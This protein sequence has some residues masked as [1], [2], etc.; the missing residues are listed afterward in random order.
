MGKEETFEDSPM[1]LEEPLLQRQVYATSPWRFYVLAVLSTFSCLQCANWFVFSSV[2]PSVAVAGFWSDFGRFC[3][4][5]DQNSSLGR[6][7]TSEKATR[8]RKTQK[9]QAFLDTGPRVGR[10][11]LAARQ[12]HDLRPPEKPRAADQADAGREGPGLGAVTSTRAAAHLDAREKTHGGALDAGRGSKVS[13]LVEASE[14]ASSRRNDSRRPSSRKV[15]P[16]G[17]RR[18]PS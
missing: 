15:S 7:V 1:P 10:R 4:K 2:E 8:T 11:P 16:R 5:L 9:S 17:P 6:R 3:S 18:R 13:T 14:Y 12:V